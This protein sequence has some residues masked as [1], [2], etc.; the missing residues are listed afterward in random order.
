[1]PQVKVCLVSESLDFTGIEEEVK[2]GTSLDNSINADEADDY[3]VGNT[4]NST[5]GGENVTLTDPQVGNITGNHSG[6]ESQ[7]KFRNG[8]ANNAKIDETEEEI[9]TSKPL[10]LSSTEYYNNASL[11]RALFCRSKRR[12]VCAK[13][14]SSKKGLFTCRVRS[15]HSNQDPTWIEYFRANEG[16]DGILA[17]LDPSYIPPPNLTLSQNSQGED[18]DTV[19]VV[20]PSEFGSEVKSQALTEAIAN[21]EDLKEAL[22]AAAANQQKAEQAKKLAQVLASMAQMEIDLPILLTSKFM[23]AAFHVDPEDGHFEICPKCGLG[24]DVICCESCPMVSHPKCAAMSEI[25]DEE[26]HCYTCVEKRKEAKD[27]ERSVKQLARTLPIERIGISEETQRGSKSKPKTEVFDFEK[28]I[29]EV[30]TILEELKQ[31]RQK[32][33]TIILGQKLVREFDG[34]EFVGEVTELLSEDVEFFKVLYEDDDEEQLTLEELQLCVASY[35]KMQK[36]TDLVKEQTKEQTPPRKLGKPRKYA[37]EEVP[38]RRSRGRLTKEPLRSPV[39][40]KLPRKRGRPR[41]RGLVD[42][43]ESQSSPPEQINMES[44]Q[45]QGQPNKRGR[46]RKSAKLLDDK[47]H[48][49]HGCPGV[50]IAHAN[51][52]QAIPPRKRGRPRK[53]SESEHLPQP[54]RGRGRPRKDEKRNASLDPPRKR[55]RTAQKALFLEYDISKGDS[56]NP[57]HVDKNMTYYCTLENDTSAKIASLIGCESWLDIAYIPENLERFPSLQDKKVKFR[58]GTLVRIAE[59]NFAKKKATLLI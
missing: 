1:V 14:V 15:A 51:S 36:C 4:I 54:V 29:D 7:I 13:C 33:M 2:E 32:Q 49:R 12:Q 35:K 58:K 10:Q 31:S 28:T 19:S 40:V 38:P 11:V 41:K 26:W 53:F 47:A 48:N 16:V 42:N 45:D 18:L 6:S 59:C 9:D 55:G 57:G 24:G 20:D 44:N 3:F 50:R 46:P 22:K 34:E 17:I 25:P 21:E 52:F 56:P 39:E 43:V 30:S 5:I 37:I 23:H 8:S 27:Q